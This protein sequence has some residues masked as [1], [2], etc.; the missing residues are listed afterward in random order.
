MIKGYWWYRAG[1]SVG[2]CE[3]VRTYGY[4]WCKAEN[5]VGK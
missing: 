3:Q 1:K 5:S 2:K 4:W